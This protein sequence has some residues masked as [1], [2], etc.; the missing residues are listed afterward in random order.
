MSC[1]HPAARPASRT[2][3]TQSTQSTPSNRL[4][5]VLRLVPLVCAAWCGNALAVDILFQGPPGSSG[6]NGATPGAPGTAGSAAPP[7]SYL[8]FGADPVNRLVVGGGAGGNGGNGANGATGQTGGAAGAGGAGAA[9]SAELSVAAPATGA[10]LAVTANGGLGGNAGQPGTGAQTGAGAAGGVG[11]TAFANGVLTSSGSGAVQ[12]VSQATGGQG[13]RSTGVLNSAAGGDALSNLTAVALGSGAVG[14]RSLATG[15][16]GAATTADGTA[17]GAGGNASANAGIGNPY[18]TLS[19]YS[20]EVRATG[21]AGGHANFDID[22]APFAYGG[23][24]GD[25]TASSGGAFNTRTGTLTLVQSATGGAGGDTVFGFAGRGGNAMSTVTSGLGG[26]LSASVDSIATGGIGGSGAGNPFTDP[27]SGTPGAGGNAA[28]TISLTGAAPA[29]G[30]WNAVIAANSTALAGVPGT[31]AFSGG[32]G[33]ADATVT[34]AGY[35]RVTGKA[36]ATG[37]YGGDQG[38]A[39]NARATVTSNYSA[40]AAATANGGGAFFNP[41][42]PATARADATSAWHAS[43]DAVAMSGSGRFGNT[44]PASAI[45]QASVN[46][47]ASRPPL[48]PA[49]LLAPEA[50]AHALASFRGGDVLARSS[51]SDASL[52]AVV[53]A[54]ASSAQPAEFYQPEAYSAANVGGNAYGPWTP[55]AAT[56]MVASYASALPDPASLAPLMA[57]SPS[58][59][60]AFDDAQVL[61]TGT[62]GAMFFPFTATAQYSVPFAAGSHLLLGLGLPYNSDFDT[63]NFEFSVSNGATELYAGSF[64]NPDQ[65]AL[66]FS[67]NVLDLGVFNTSTL[68]LLVRFSFN[69]GIY[70]FSYVLG[71]GNALTP[72]PE[73]GTWLMLVLG[74]ALLA[75]RG[76]AFRRLPARV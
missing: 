39:A 40:V 75:W 10:S 69:G 19:S 41:G 68:D 25:A 59:A 2:S 11:G 44:E 34:I 72:V 49:S 4:R 43:A 35:G 28:S 3:S 52:G 76:G 26:A 21:G 33:T 9:T 70:G 60:A 53:V 45:A 54:T 29:A 51:Y 27:L 15:G 63:A 30:S 32:G 14:V 20:Q 55:D 42:A 6:V 61:G 24:G 1:N 66:F 8:L 64:N 37:A 36:L 47:A 23:R 7:A 71:A 74:L 18:A 48:P 13:G 73:P 58:I 17:G 31:G 22:N 38:G 46:R 56:G 50:R 12:G 5:T 57:A 67:D 65:A 16:Q 62:M